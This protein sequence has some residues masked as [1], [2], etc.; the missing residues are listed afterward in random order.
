ML[1]SPARYIGQGLDDAALLY[2][3]PRGTARCLAIN[4]QKTDGHTDDG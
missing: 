4:A 1:V 3:Q 2:A